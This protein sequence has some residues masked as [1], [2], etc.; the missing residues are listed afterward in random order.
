MQSIVKIQRKLKE[1]G[2]Y[3]LTIDG[4]WGPSSQKALLQATAQNKVEIYFDFKLF[5]LCRKN[6]NCYDY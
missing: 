5:K 4:I 3:N 1:L 6:D 2:Y